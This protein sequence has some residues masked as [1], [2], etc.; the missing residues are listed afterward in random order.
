MIK[1]SR[2]IGHLSID[3]LERVDVCWDGGRCFESID[4]LL[5]FEREIKQHDLDR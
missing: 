4:G 5:Y 3:D 2:Q 1:L